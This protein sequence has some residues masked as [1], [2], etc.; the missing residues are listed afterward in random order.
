MHADA[1][2]FH[3]TVVVV[4]VVVVVTL[5]V[6]GSGQDPGDEC[7]RIGCVPVRVK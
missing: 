6:G 7:G 2:R 1:R 5:M 4:V 3:G